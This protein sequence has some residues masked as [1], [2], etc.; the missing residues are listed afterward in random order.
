VRV[1]VDA[2]RCVGHGLCYARSPEVFADD[3][4][5]YS[6]VRVEGDVP[7]GLEDSARVAAANCPERAISVT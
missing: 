5:G 6:R 4:E 3:E 7:A 1:R 2:D